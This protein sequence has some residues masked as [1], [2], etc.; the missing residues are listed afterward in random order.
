MLIKKMPGDE[1]NYNVHHVYIIS[2]MTS[3][4]LTA[5]LQKLSYIMFLK[6]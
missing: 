4:R 6:L 3:H 1:A 5:E 2:V